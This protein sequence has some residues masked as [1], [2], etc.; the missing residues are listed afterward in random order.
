M[1]DMFRLLFSRRW[2]WTTLL[3]IIGIGVTIRLGFWQLDRNDQRQAEISHIQKVQSMPVLDLNKRP[4]PD[5][6]TDMEYRL[7]NVTGVYDFDHQVVLLN[8]VRKRMTGT[9]PGVALLTPLILEDGQAVL[10]ERGWIPLE[11]NTP[12]SWRQFDQPGK[13]QVQGVLRQSLDKGEMGSTVRD[14]TLSPGETSLDYWNFVNLPRL[15]EQL[16]YP[17]LDMYIQ[18]APGTDPETL[19]HSL[20]EQPDLDPGAH[21]GFALQWFFYTGLLL[22]GYPV[23]LRRQKKPSQNR[24]GIK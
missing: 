24:E 9:D 4:I 22:V 8:Q 13:I 3:V 11:Y 18:E 12:E 17:L 23:W 7:V 14:P 10:I 19:P 5:D 21:I 1:T 2:W 16:P 15:Q 6:L 20:F